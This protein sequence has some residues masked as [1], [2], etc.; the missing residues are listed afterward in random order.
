MPAL[1]EGANKRVATAE[2]IQAH[3]QKVADGSTCEYSTISI[4][5]DP[6]YSDAV[7][8]FVAQVARKIGFGEDGDRIYRDRRESGP[9]PCN[10]LRF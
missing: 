4:P 10:D 6:A 9:I 7:G 5:N 8:R 1:T 3:C 2:D